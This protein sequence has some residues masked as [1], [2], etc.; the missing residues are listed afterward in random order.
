[1]FPAARSVHR[2]LL[3]T[4][5]LLL[6]AS[7]AMA[8][9][10]KNIIALRE[11]KGGDAPRVKRVLIL[12]ALGRDFAPF[13]A[14][15]SSFRTALA[16]QSATP[17][18]FFEASLESTLFAEDGS[19][20]FLVDYLRARFANRPADLVVPI[21]APGL[22]FL[23]RHRDKLFPGVPILVVGPDERR[24]SNLRSDANATAIG[25]NFD[26]PGIIQNI[27]QTFPSTT[28]IEVV[29]GNSPFEK[30][31]MTE[32]R[33]D[34]QPFT[35]RVRFEWLNELS[36]EAIR[37]R[38][39]T[40]PRDSA[41]LYFL[42]V[43]DAAAVPH[44]QDEALDKLRRDSNAPIF[45]IFDHQLGRGIVGG[46]LYPYQEASQVAARVALQILNGSPTSSIEP[47]FLG[48]AAP[49]YDWRELRR[50]G[51]N[52]SRLPPGS[53]VQF[54]SPSLWEQY[55]WYIIGALAIIT[56][57]ASLIAGLLLH[58]ARRRRAEAELRQSQ[59]FMELSTSAGELGLWVRDL[60]QGGFWANP[61]LRSLFGFSENQVLRFADI[62]DRIHPDDRVRVIDEAEHAHQA[63]VSFEGEF[64]VVIPDHG[65]RWVGAE[66]GPSM[67]LAET[68]PAGWVL[69]L[70]LL[71]VSGP[72]KIL[73][74]HL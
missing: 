19:E 42:L 27:L 18:E 54:R 36:F 29:T 58:R 67:S 24:M 56:V 10:A 30:F 4:F 57:Q 43:V 48:P 22:M 28:R 32:L 55:R 47:V 9:E 65:E 23:Q 51:I 40:L 35:D 7:P 16:E 46:P 14:L 17:I 34:V 44:E 62:V 38:L 2:F 11:G 26:F 15:S 52:E 69:C 8:Q 3:S 1:M 13:N 71:S 63:G 66:D 74:R 33:R 70:T 25:I 50:W 21:G 73:T 61:R 45:G 68:A 31:W 49:A 12:H 20:A 60:Q 53:V 39:A 5:C 41:I 37:R 72:S 64:R 59:E 6:L